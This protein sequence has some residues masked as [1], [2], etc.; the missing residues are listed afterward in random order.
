MYW[1]M[2]RSELL[3]RR[4]QTIVVAVGL[5]IA[6]ALVIVVSSLST[7]IKQAQTQALEGVTG[8]GTDL[9]VTGAAAEPGQGGGGPRFDF[10]SESGDTDDAG[11]TRVA[12][13]NLMTQPGRGTLDASAVSTIAELD[14]VAAATGTLSLTNTSF[15]GELPD[16]SQTSD[17]AAGEAATGDAAGSAPGGF[18]G[19]GGGF[20]GGSFGVDSFSVLGVDPAATDVGPLSATEITDGRALTADDADALVAVVD[21]SYATAQ[22]LAVGD[23]LE[24]G[25]DSVEIV[26]VLASTSTDADAAANVFLPLGT[27]RVLS[28]S[29]DVVST[30]YV[31]ANDS[32]SIDGVQAEIESA[33]PDATVN[34]QA[35][36]AAQVS[37]SLASASSL[38]GSLGTWLSMIVLAVALAIA[39]LLTGAGVA[40][41]TREFG[42][43]KAIGWSNGRI[44]GQLAGE[45]GVQA[46]IGGAA[47]L[48]LG[49]GAIG[50]INL[51]SPT[52]QAATG[53][54]TAGGPGTGSGMQGGGM[55]S[56][57]MQGGGM[58]GSDAAGSTSGSDASGA[59]GGFGGGGGFGQTASSTAD[60]V[61]HAP[62][63]L[64]VVLA[65]LG[66]SL[67][68]GLLAGAFASWRA[69]RLSPVEALRAVA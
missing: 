47:G 32:S 18:G 58:P 69:A 59:M 1:T 30:V 15:S 24:V 43:L 29:D 16:M 68:G 22:D 34:S 10:G 40:R 39:V 52:L 31:V 38:I 61:L 53:S 64:W 20:G 19:G 2:L 49:L 45:S 33:L 65:A 37:G 57:G 66:L 17:P 36:L 13:S 42:T 60:I 26:G 56:G 9:T 67:L 35:D 41:R 62:V 7:G 51:I 54:G 48:V 4:R 11:T 5:A 23:T 8:V 25:S 14:D 27:A 28:D 63:T 50:I 55:Q 46:L 44:I 3:G 6:I 12:Q 21:A